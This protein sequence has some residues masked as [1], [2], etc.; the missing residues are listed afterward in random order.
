MSTPFARLGRFAAR[1]PRTVIVAWLC[2]A[3][4]VI[5]ASVTQG[6]RLQDTLT[7]PGADSQRAGDLLQRAGSAAGGMSERVVITPR[8]STATFDSP[9]VRSAAADLRARLSAIP[10]VR[11][12]AD[13][14]ARVSP[15]G[16]VAVADM[17]YPPAEALDARD[18]TRLD[19]ALDAARAGAPGR[20][21]RIEAAGELH[22]TFT[23]PTS[24]TGEVVGVAV[25]ALIL[26]V[27]FR[28]IVA[29]GLPI[30]LALAGLGIGLAIIPL[31]ARVMDFPSAGIAVAAMVG[32]GVGIDYALLIVTRHREHLAA[33]MPVADAV[34]RAVATAGRSV[35]TAGGIVVI[36]ILGLVVA[37]LPFI[38]A[39]GVGM[40]LVM[41]L[42][43][44]ASITLLPAVL[45]LLG[46]RVNRLAV[47]RRGAVDGGTR[48]WERWACRVT[49]RPVAFMLVGIAIL[50]ALAAPAAA[51]RLGVPDD[52]T[53]PT[54]RTERGA[55]DLM[56][57]GFGPGANA[58]VLVAVETAG[59]GAAAGRVRAALM[60]DPGIASVGAPATSTGVATLTAIPT[61]A[62]Q[63]DATRATIDR[64]RARVIPDALAGSPARAYVGGQTASML[65]MSA[66]V[67][68]RLPWLIAAVVGSS[69]LL[70][71]IMFRSV[72]VPI[73]AAVLNLLSIGA[74]YG[75]LVAVFLWGW[76]A[77]LLGL[78]TTVPILSFIPMFMFAIVFGLSMDYE[79]FLLSRMREH[80]LATG[81]NDAA[82]VRGLS[83]TGRVITSAALIMVVVFLGFATAADPL[84]KMLGLGLATAILVDA[85]VVRM[86]LLP[87]AMRLMGRAN[88]WAPRWMRRLLPGGSPDA[89]TA[90]GASKRPR[91]PSRASLGD[92]DVR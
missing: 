5:G 37:G 70:L 41:G 73:K 28:S 85:T 90:T 40:A 65:D 74:A 54:S 6:V 43:V 7:V 78:E 51:L 47:H 84:T 42:M 62:P 91:R 76:G 80:M 34:S 88:W 67:Q 45:T 9:E 77:S 32:L 36:S 92:G 22:F 13:P 53:L 24:G 35:L 25:A 4:I 26:L 75:G 64:L 49:R 55:Y 69:M 71:A 86:I 56:A 48:A 81:D 1:R 50:V 8:A 63:A 82:V 89:V 58:P 20:A 87:A 15:D 27:A 57:Q 79:V 18:L 3:A 12:V 38:T 16:R 44:A 14:L 46:H 23:Q 61:G 52:G 30:L 10:N 17:V 2:L 21:L 68:E 19:A 60:R 33:G 29:A 11:S 39:S 72:V 59:D 66:R 31:I 83:S